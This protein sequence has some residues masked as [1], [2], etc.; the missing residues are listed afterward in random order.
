MSQYESPSRISYPAIVEGTK[1]HL[2]TSAALKILT[3][4]TWSHETFVMPRALS[5]IHIPPNS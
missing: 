2:E 3:L 1:L 5:Q 4:T